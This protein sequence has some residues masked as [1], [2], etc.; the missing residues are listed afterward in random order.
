MMVKKE[1]RAFL[2]MLAYSELGELAHRKDQGYSV[3]VGSKPGAVI[4]IKSFGDHPR[5]AVQLTESLWSTAAGRYQIVQKTFDTY[6]IILGL[7][8]FKP[9]SQD[10]IALQLLAEK[11]ALHQIV[12]GDIP[13]A[14]HRVRKVWASLPGAGY[15]QHE[16]RLEM[17]MAYYE[18]AMKA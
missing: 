17:L 16:N 7:S 11:G 2:D 3:I 18:K 12:C 13:G 5:V 10:A 8:D 14:I 4:K 6:R 15:G 1:L 9:R